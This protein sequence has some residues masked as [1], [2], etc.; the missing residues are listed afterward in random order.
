M[1]R[2]VA[3]AILMLAACEPSPEEP[4]LDGAPELDGAPVT[5]P[6]TPVDLG[7]TSPAVNAGPPGLLGIVPPTGVQVIDSCETVIAA[8]YD[9]PPKMACLL[10]QTEDSVKGQLDA[11]VFAA[12]SEAG[13]SQVRAQG[14]QYYFERP[15]TGTDCAEVAVLSVVT[16]RLQA[17]LDHAGAGAPAGS[18]V[19]QAYAIPASTLEACGVD[20]MKP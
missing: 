8:D 3:I 1:K 15:R 10:F 20:R 7:G 2:L 6:E 16:G 19:W 4:S 12:I 11:G 14:D 9:R 18:A 5:A 17:V 13:W